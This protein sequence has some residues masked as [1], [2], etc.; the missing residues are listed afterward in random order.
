[1]YPINQR[2]SGTYA[3]YNASLTEPK[4]GSRELLLQDK[5]LHYNMSIDC[6]FLVTFWLLTL[7]VSDLHIIEYFSDYKIGQLTEKS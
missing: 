5:M 2:V 4:T 6:V 1:M 3:K 7:I